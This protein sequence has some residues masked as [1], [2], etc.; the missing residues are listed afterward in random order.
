[1]SAN[2]QVSPV[3]A[4]I[5]P[6]LAA[7]DSDL[8]GQ[9]EGAILKSAK[10]LS[11]FRKETP[12][13]L[14]RVIDKLID[15]AD[16]GR[17]TLEET[18]KTEKTFLG[19]KV[20]MA[21]RLWFGFPWGKVL[22]LSVDGIET[23]IKNT[24]GE[25]WMIPREAI[26]RPCLLVKE[27]ERKARFSIGIIVARRA[28]LG[29][30]NQDRKRSISKIGR[31]HIHWILKDEPYPKNAWQDVSNEVRRRVAT[32]ASGTKRIDTLFR[33][34]QKKPISRE[35]ILAVA[36]QKD[37]MKR[38]RK[39]GGARDSLSKDGIALLSGKY[40]RSL[41]ESLGLPECGKDDFISYRPT[42]PSDQSIL[43]KAGKI[44]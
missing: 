7:K 17:F 19:T 3:V 8:I 24:M 35:D 2:R 29:A 11:N 43:R 12:L 10:G 14:R 4:P 40:D 6:E 1:M 31:D 38:L 22:D 34:L 28:Y 37:A 9:I 39:N 13:L 41:I 23:D 26:D 25:T 18:E 20:E 21:L 15:T 27:D 36:R 33:E 16:T 32:P 5:D 30:E 42:T 44:R